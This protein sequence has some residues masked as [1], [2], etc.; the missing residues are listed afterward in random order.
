MKRLSLITAEEKE[1]KRLEAKRI[2]NKKWRDSHPE[3]IKRYRKLNRDKL[4][5]YFR[6]YRRKYTKTSKRFKEWNKDYRKKYAARIKLEVLK[7]YGENGIPKCKCC[8][9]KNIEFLTLEHPLGGGKKERRK[10]GRGV[11]YYNYLRKNNYPIEL[12]VLCFNCNLS[13]GIYGYCPHKRD[14]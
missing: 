7:H 1:N 6:E 9:E 5:K 10:H 12:E 11:T 3:V 8:G 13:K 4:R 14:K 2:S